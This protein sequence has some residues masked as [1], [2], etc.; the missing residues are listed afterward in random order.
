MIKDNN[1]DEKIKVIRPFG[2]SIARVKMSNE[3]VDNLNNYIDKIILDKSKSNELDHGKKLAGHVSQEFKLEEEI[4]T[5]SG[6]LKFL[7]D[8]VSGWMKLSENQEVSEFKLINS[9][10]VR[11][12]ENE[13]N[14]VH[15]HGGHISGVG[16]LK[17]PKFLGEN[18]QKDKKYNNNGK[19]EF[20]HGSRQYLSQATLSVTPEL[21]YF[22][23]FPHYLMHTV[24]PFKNSEDERRS[25][26]F[27]ALI[28]EKIFNV[29]KT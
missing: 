22:Y 20:I 12:F 27:N 26:S 25:V 6:F 4:L 28:D 14:P 19:I 21:G 1:N 24:Y 18:P 2:P 15:W 23:F 7:A 8:S 3:L 9:W 29:F 16:Y 5:K 11:Q 17:V 10:V 13:Y